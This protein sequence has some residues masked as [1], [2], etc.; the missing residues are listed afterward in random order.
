MF[1][2]AYQSGQNQY[3]IIVGIKDEL[4]NMDSFSDACYIAQLTTNNSNSIIVKSIIKDD[5]GLTIYEDANIS[6]LNI[7]ENT[8][9]IISIICYSIF[10]EKIL[11]FYSPKEYKIEN[12]DMPIE[13]YFN[14]EVKLNLKNYFKFNYTHII[15]NT[16]TVYITFNIYNDYTFIF[17]KPNKNYILPISGKIKLSL[18][19]SGTY[20]IKIIPVRAVTQSTSDESFMMFIPY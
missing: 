13:I 2:S 3:Y 9:L 15:N 5:S 18:T 1:N 17:I 8:E 6:K 11:L 14:K 19:E 7:K 10:T 4:N 20:Y 12:D 16:Q